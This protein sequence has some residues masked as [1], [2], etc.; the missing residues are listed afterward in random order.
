MTRTEYQTPR[1]IVYTRIS[2]DQAAD[3]HG[4]VNQLAACEKHAAARGWTVVA[5][6]SDNDLSATSGVH[7]PG[8]ERGLEM[9]AAGQADVLV[10]WK[11]DRFVRRVRDLEDVI[12][13]FERAGAKLASV[14]GDLDLS[15]SSGR[16]VGRMLAV[17]AKGEME[18]KGARQRLAA[19]EA[20]AAGKRWTGCP[21]PFG[22]AADHVTPAPAEAT[23]VATACKWLIGGSTI[24][25]VAREWD[26]RGLRPPQAP[27][28]PLPAQG[29]TRNS[30]TTILKNPRIAGLS[31]YRG[32]IIGPGDWTPLVPE[33]TWR[34]ATAILDTRD[35]TITDKNGKIRRVKARTEA[36]VRTL[37]GGLAQCRC[38]N[39]VTSSVN[40][41][42]KHVYRCSPS[43]RNG[44]PG[45]HCQQMSGP[46]DRYVE[47]VITARLAR[48]DAADLIT[49]PRPDTA[50]LHAEAAAI[51]RNLNEL[52]ADRALGIVSRAQMIA[53]TAR[54]NARLDQITAV[55]AESASSSALA[56]FAAGQAA[57][58]WEA[59]D[60][61]RKRA[62]IG[63]LAT[64]TLHPAGRGARTFDPDTV[65]FTPLHAV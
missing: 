37:L 40:S 21:R 35:R 17:V 16:L 29:W 32:E 65:T 56:P 22:Y 13:I 2:K 27:Y 14:D 24:S 31:A 19:G 6:L 61:A 44:R 10:C 41:T 23:A 33:E 30:V 9:I 39:V 51:R 28:G 7:R 53:A 3:E 26:R 38:G 11:L 57:A 46:V 47:R 20:A 50:P 54:G 1:V 55:L 45:P 25:A 5:R 12:E 8:Y 48:D 42:G 18:T 15:T 58:V 64:V 4:V 60:P 43:T 34:A 36:G 59:L 49:P 52:A 62:V 63:A